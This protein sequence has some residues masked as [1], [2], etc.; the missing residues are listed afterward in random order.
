[1]SLFEELNHLRDRFDE[2]FDLHKAHREALDAVKDDIDNLDLEVLETFYLIEYVKSRLSCDIKKKSLDPIT[3]KKMNETKVKLKH[4][5][6]KLE[7]LNDHV[8]VAWEEFVRRRS[9]K[10]RR[11]SSI[12][13]IYKALATNQKVITLLKRKVEIEPERHVGMTCNAD[14]N[15][16]IRPKIEDHSRFKEFL[17]SR[18]VVPVRKPIR[19]NQ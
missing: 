2:A 4:I 12:D 3:L 1:M 15:P 17:A 6:A 14:K 16:V 8:D 13:T 5:E 11:V 19:L 10:E 18:G 7:E 9:N